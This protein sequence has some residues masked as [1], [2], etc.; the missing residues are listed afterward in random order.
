MSHQRPKAPRNQTPAS[1][2]SCSVG[3]AIHLRAAAEPAA[4]E[5]CWAAAPAGTATIEKKPNEWKA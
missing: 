5:G 2:A 3:S 1:K 4:P